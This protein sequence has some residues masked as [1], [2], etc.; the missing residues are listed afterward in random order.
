MPLLVG[1]MGAIVAGAEIH[2]ALSARSQCELEISLQIGV[3][4][5]Q[6]PYPASKRNRNGFR[7]R[8]AAVHQ[9]SSVHIK[10]SLKL[11]LI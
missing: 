2:I 10:R 8:L 11:R 4:H 1:D 3:D 9:N 6:W 5:L 7:N